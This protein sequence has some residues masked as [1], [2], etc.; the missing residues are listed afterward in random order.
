MRF[1]TEI[2]IAPWS[3]KIEYGD[4]ILTLGSCFAHNMAQRLAERKFMVVANPTG[5][6]FNPCSIAYSITRIRQNIIPSA[7]DL[8]YHEERYLNYDFH[9]SI[10]GLTP[11][12][13]T[14]KMTEALASGR[15]AI[16]SA[17]HL[18]VTLGTAWVYRHKESGRVVANCHKQPHTLFRRELMSVSEVIEALEEIV[19]ST[20]AQVVFT[21]SPIR[22]IGDGLEQNSLSKA[23]LRVAIDTV[24]RRHP[25]RVLYFPAYEIMMD[26]LRDYRFYESD[27]LHPTTQAVEYIAD[28]FFDVALSSKTKTTMQQVERIVAARN[29]RSNNPASESYKEFCRKQIADIDTLQGI[30][31]SEERAWFNER[32]K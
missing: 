6:L 15:K 19:T 32:L 10:S 2:D 4:T 7:D 28:R 26:D 1:R 25:E 20:T 22:H 9:S 17:S 14:A 21:V 18:I 5:I 29:H 23:V 12:E 8:I 31:M 24:C 27:M 30:D 16:D 3:K 11:K 13:A